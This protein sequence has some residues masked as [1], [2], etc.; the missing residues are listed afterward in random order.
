MKLDRLRGKYVAFLPAEFMGEVNKYIGELNASILMA[1]KGVDATGRPLEFR[2]M[3]GSQIKKLEPVV[4][5]AR[6]IMGSDALT[7]GNAALIALHEPNPA[8]DLTKEWIRELLA[9]TASAAV[10]LTH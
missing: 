8:M 2:G 3:F 10:R 4:N 9:K 5:S 6:K 7:T 1:E